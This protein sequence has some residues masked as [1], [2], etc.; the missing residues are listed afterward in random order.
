MEIKAA[1]RDFRFG[2][3]HIRDFH[4]CA[5]VGASKWVEWCV[6]I[7]VPFFKINKQFATFDQGRHYL[8]YGE[9]GVVSQLHALHIQDQ[10]FKNVG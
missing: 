6:K 4:R 10:G 1:W 7:T 3:R 5:L 2:M 9:K 8:L